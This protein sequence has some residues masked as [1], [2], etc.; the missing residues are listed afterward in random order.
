MQCSRCQYKNLVKAN[1]CGSCGQ[2]LINSRD[3]LNYKKSVRKI[4]VFFFLTLAYLASTYFAEHGRTYI[5]MLINGFVLGG[6]TIVFYLMDYKQI[7]RLLRFGHLRKSILIRVLIGAPLFSAIIWYAV[8]IVN[9]AFLDGAQFN[10]YDL[11][12]DSPAP[13]IFSLLSVALLPALF[14]EIAFRGVVFNELI[15]ITGIKSA[16]VIS[17]VLFTI[18]HLSVLSFIWIFP[19]GLVFGYLRARYRT[20]WY[21]I[22]GHFVYNGSIVVIDIF[23]SVSV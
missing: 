23:T 10:Y 22:I 5:H 14:E 15:R 3:T 6:V 18:I 11:F 8:C 21:G 16:I 12:R 1:Y 2:K 13:I 20:L 4:A 19:I 17:S 7:N 9:S